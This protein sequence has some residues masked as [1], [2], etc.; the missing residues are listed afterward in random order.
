MNNY[1]QSLSHSRQQP[2]SYNNNNNRKLIEDAGYIEGTA[3]SFNDEQQN[4][5][6]SIV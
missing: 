5:L 4:A 3:L 2:I 1:E 6:T